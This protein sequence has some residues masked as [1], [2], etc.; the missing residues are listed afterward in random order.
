MFVICVATINDQFKI[1]MRDKITPKC[2]HLDKSASQIPFELNVFYC[3]KTI[4]FDG[5]HMST[6][7]SFH[8]LDTYIYFRISCILS[9]S[10]LVCN[11]T[12]VKPQTEDNI[13]FVHFVGCDIKN[14]KCN[15]KKASLK[16]ILQINLNFLSILNY[17]GWQIL[18]NALYGTLKFV[19]IFSQPT[20]SCHGNNVMHP[21]MIYLLYN[22]S[23][24][25]KT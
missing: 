14:K 22:Y 4:L 24:V 25:L 13:R 8:F 17:S 1:D 3:A 15:H 6:N 5:L 19:I 2:T 16:H 23:I 7:N 10:T 12:S 20:T 21:F 9:S 18:N 11:H